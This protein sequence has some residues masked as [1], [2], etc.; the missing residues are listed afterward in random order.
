MYQNPYNQYGPN[1]QPMFDMK[2]SQKH[3]EDFYE[4][5]FIELCKFG[6]IEE[7]NICSNLGEHLVGNVYVKFYK[8]EAAKNALEQVLGR[9]YAGRPII[10]ELSPVTD[11]REARCR[12]YDQ[13]DCARGGFCNFLH[14]REVD[15]RRV[16]ELFGAQRKL[17]KKIREKERE[18]RAKRRRRSSSKSRSRSRSRDKKKRKTQRSSRRE[19]SRSPKERDG[20]R[21]DKEKDKDNKDKD[22]DRDRKD[23][24]KNEPKEEQSILE[25]AIKEE[26][27]EPREAV[28]SN[29]EAANE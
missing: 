4:D 12:Q 23:K 20:S 5:L 21:K 26:P 22:K 8:E 13:G 11:F 17:Y 9:F 24:V 1:G 25:T 10:A 28:L 3:F 15:R 6:E 19:R 2:E 7:L 16:R 29:G 14:L 27:I 18:E